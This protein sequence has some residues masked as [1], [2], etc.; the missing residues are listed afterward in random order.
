MQEGHDLTTV[1]EMK[2]AL[3]SNGGLDGVRVQSL[4]LLPVQYLAIKNNPK[5]PLSTS[6]ITFNM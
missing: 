6:L 2:M 5:L 1:E 4:L 3:V